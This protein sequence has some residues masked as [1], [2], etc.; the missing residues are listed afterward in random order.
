[1]PK[2]VPW[3]ALDVINGLAKLPLWSLGGDGQP[4]CFPHLPDLV[5][6]LPVNVGS[7]LQNMVTDAKQQPW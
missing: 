2:A 4:R 7:Y 1:M 3:K 6:Y 5:A